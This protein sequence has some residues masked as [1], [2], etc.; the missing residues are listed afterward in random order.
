M[1]RPGIQ[2]QNPGT[3]ASSSLFSSHVR[4]IGRLQRWRN[5]TYWVLKQGDF[6]VTPDGTNLAAVQR[7]INA[8]FK[9]PKMFVD[10]QFEPVFYS[11]L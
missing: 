9:Q 1:T 2:R 8:L 10:F 7:P 5:V 3:L 11:D 6:G 4:F